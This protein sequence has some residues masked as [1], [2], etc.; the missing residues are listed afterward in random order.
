MALSNL[1][2][3]I[4]VVYIIGLIS[5]ALWVSRDKAGHQKDTSDYFLAG[6]SLPWWAVARIFGKKIRWSCA[7]R[8]SFFLACGLCIYKLNRG[9]VVGFI[10]DKQLNRF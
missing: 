4:V 8:I 5:L 7:Y 3:G 10:S 9:I 2:I 6:R 1:D